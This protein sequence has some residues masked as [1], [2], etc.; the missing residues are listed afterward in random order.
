MTRR[1]SPPLP[2]PLLL[3]ALLGGCCCWSAVPGAH[4]APA[5]SLASADQ[6]LLGMSHAPSG[7]AA[8]GIAERRRL[9]SGLCAWLGLGLRH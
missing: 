7:A 6:Q 4:G 3:L 8:E 1:P 5:G 9:Q 2:L